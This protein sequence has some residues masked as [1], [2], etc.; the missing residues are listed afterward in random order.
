[1]ALDELSRF[2]GHP[3]RYFTQRR[4]KAY[5]S[6]RE[7]EEKEDEPFALDGLAGYQLREALL[8]AML[9]DDEA[10]FVERLSLTGDLPYG[11]LGRLSLQKSRGQCQQ[12]FTVLQGYSLEECEPIEVN[13]SLGSIVLQAWLDRPTATT[14]LSYRIGDLSA[15]QKMQVWIE[16]LALCAQGTPKQHHLINL[17]KT[18]KLLQ[19]GFILISP[20]EAKEHLTNMLA[21]LQQGLCQPLAL[22]AKT[23]DAWCKS[24]CSSKTEGD[25]DRAWEQ[26]LKTYQES[27]SA[28]ARSEVDDAYWQRYYPDLSEQKDNFVSMCELIWLPMHRHLE[29]FE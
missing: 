29:V 6:L 22:P 8:Q 1:M 23:A 27:S 12:L 21:L 5:L 26:A 17:S 2:I 4:L 14:R 11:A 10:T 28:F 25:A 3:T 7:E 20:D 15:H 16:H 24:Y 9:K 18:G 19:H 13:L